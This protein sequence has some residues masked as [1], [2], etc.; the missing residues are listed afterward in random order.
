MKDAAPIAA[1]EMPIA[2]DAVLDVSDSLNADSQLRWDAPGRRR[3]SHRLRCPAP[4]V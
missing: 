4:K 3:L 1:G 2:A